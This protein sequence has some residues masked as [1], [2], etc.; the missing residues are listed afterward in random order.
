[1]RIVFATVAVL[2]ALAPAAEAKSFRGETSQKRFAS[3]VVGSDG[4]VTRIRISYSAPCGDP[5]YRFPN[6][7]R[8]E[9]PFDASTPDE[10]TETLK[11]TD[12]LSGGGRSRQTVTV[13]AR[14][15]DRRRRQPSP[16]AARSRPA[17]C[18]RAAAR[19]S[20]SASSS[21]SPGRRRLLLERH[22]QRLRRPCCRPCRR[23]RR[24]AKSLARLSVFS[25]VRAFAKSLMDRRRPGGHRR[26]ERPDGAAELVLLAVALSSESVKVAL[27]FS[28]VVRTI[29]G[30][31]LL[32]GVLE[33]D[34]GR[35]QVRGAPPGAGR[36][37][38]HRDD[39]TGGAVTVMR[40]SRRRTQPAVSSSSGGVDKRIG[41]RRTPARA[42]RR[43]SRRSGNASLPCSGS[44]T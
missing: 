40:S 42:Y 11:L 16:G 38:G 35:G 15:H 13:T 5:R 2:L 44:P 6:V 25:A 8:L 7:L 18:S 23:P 3:V 34:R 4:L 20:T 39:P 29:G 27:E 1:M 24:S 30:G 43:P 41:C 33:A 36:R 32:G 12:K 21:A 10:V 37:N 19:R 14:P 9:P 28:L 22:R 26:L 17:R 31:L